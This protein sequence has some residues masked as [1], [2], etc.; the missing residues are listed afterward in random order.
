MDC[1]N[2]ANIGACAAI[3]ANFGID[4][5]NVAFFDRF[6]GTLVYASSASS[7]IFVDFIS[8][9]WKSFCPLVKGTGL[10]NYLLGA[11]IL[12]F[13]K[14]NFLFLFE[15]QHSGIEIR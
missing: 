15:I 2:R 6:N 1:L 11:N 7:A 3:R 4:Y 10:I 5:I 14:S 12:I 8:H 13:R 9:D